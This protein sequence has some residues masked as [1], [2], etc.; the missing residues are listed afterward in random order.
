MRGACAAPAHN[1]PAQAP[2][3][4]KRRRV[5]RGK[6]RQPKRTKA[7]AKTA[8]NP[9]L[10]WVH[11][12]AQKSRAS[13]A[14][15]IHPYRLQTENPQAN[16]TVSFGLRS[17]ELRNTTYSILSGVSR[18]AECVLHV[19]DGLDLIPSNID[20]AGAE[21]ELSTAIGREQILRDA[22]ADLMI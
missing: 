12:T 4:K 10:D 3:A 16:A 8:D 7:R 19:A 2:K 18:P 5:K 13:P 1:R 22:L 21:M 20:L 6:N 11:K 15:G 17:H 9:I 14:A